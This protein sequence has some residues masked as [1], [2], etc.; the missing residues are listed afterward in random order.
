MMTVHHSHSSPAR[1]PV[2]SNSAVEADVWELPDPWDDYPIWDDWHLVE[3]AR[4]EPDETD[5]LLS[6]LTQLTLSSLSSYQ[7][8]VELATD[9][10]LQA[11]A[12]VVLRQRSAQCQELLQQTPRWVDDP[13]EHKESLAAIRSAW[14][15]A[16][17]NL[18]Q[19]HQA[20]FAECA[21]R[22]ESLLEEAYLLAA[23]TLR[24]EAWRKK[25]TE[26]AVMVYGARSIWEE[27]AEEATHERVF[28]E[29]RNTA[30]RRLKRFIPPPCVAQ[31]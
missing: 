4:G 17:W 3:I 13:D 21:E 31:D 26:F 6:Q 22:A 16:V 8:I 2:V 29:P 11:F 10:H 24:D 30:G 9:A 20:A 23:K 28:A 7:E 14:R 18:E 1:T 25:L 15:L 5:L 19:N 27:L 12:E